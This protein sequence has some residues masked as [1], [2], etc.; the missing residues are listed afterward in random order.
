LGGFPGRA[1]ERRSPFDQPFRRNRR[2]GPQFRIADI[3]GAGAGKGAA[4]RPDAAAITGAPLIF[5]RI[6]REIAAVAQA[7]RSER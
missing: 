7:G 3:D 2:R 4:E 5:E 1:R 6:D